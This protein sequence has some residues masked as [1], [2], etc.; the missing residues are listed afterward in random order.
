METFVLIVRIL[1]QVLS[2]AVI[3]TE[4]VFKLKRL[5]E[6]DPDVSVSIRRLTDVAIA[7]DDEFDRLYAEWKQRQGL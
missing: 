4:A 7:A 6:L 5:L 2:F 1:D 3:G